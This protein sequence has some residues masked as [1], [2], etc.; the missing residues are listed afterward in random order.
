MTSCR[1][2]NLH[3]IFLILTVDCGSL[4]DPANGQVSHTAGTRFGQT[5][6]YSCNT[7]YNLVGDSTRTCQATGNWSGSVPT[8]QGIQAYTQATCQYVFSPCILSKLET[9][10]KWYD[11]AAWTL[12]RIQALENCSP[13]LSCA[14]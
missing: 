3:D 5:A 2:I 12:G 1:C 13:N 11:S 10:W 14:M 8:C 6:T 4:T 9:I 7:G